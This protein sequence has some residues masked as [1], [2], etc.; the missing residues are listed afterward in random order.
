M[1]KGVQDIFNR[2][3]AQEGDFLKREFLSPVHLA[4]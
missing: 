4:A 3:A 1:K 2:L